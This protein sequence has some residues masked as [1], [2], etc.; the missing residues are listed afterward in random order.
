MFIRYKAMVF[1]IEIQFQ[2]T[3]MA[4]LYGKLSDQ[5]NEVYIVIVYTIVR[6]T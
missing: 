4:S 2:C 3:S 6:V 5:N 1:D